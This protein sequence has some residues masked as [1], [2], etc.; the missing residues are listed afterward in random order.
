[1]PKRTLLALCALCFVFAVSCGSSFRHIQ[2]RAVSEAECL[3]AEAA[4]KDLQGDEITAADSL[5]TMAKSNKAERE[6]A[7][8][9]DLAAAYYRIALARQSVE[10]SAKTLKQA[11]ASLAVSQEQVNKYQDILNRVNSNAGEQ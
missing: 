1:M 7:D 10:E 2:V 3:Q 8:F 6:S 5:L 9:A 4:A 11:K